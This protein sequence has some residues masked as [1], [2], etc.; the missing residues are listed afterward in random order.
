MRRTAPSWKTF[1]PTPQPTNTLHSF[2]IF[3][4]RENCHR[5][6]PRLREAMPNLE[7]WRSVLEKIEQS[8]LEIA[9]RYHCFVGHF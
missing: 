8:G 3:G 6:L 5:K 7:W 4:I 9:T 2:E 1:H